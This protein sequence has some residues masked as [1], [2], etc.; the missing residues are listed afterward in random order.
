MSPRNIVRHA[1]KN[2]LD[3]IGICDHN[4]CENVPHVKKCA[5]DEELYIIGGME[6]TSS[7]EVHILALFDEEEQLFSM[8]EFVYDHLTGTNDE[9]FYGEQVVVDENDEIIEY[10]TK[11]LIGA[12]ELTV[13]QIV[14][15]IHQLNGLAIA[16]HVDR[17]SFSIIGQLG[18][19]PV[20]LLI[21]AIEVS[22]NDKASSFT[23]LNLPLITSSDAHTLDAIGRSVTDFYMEEVNIETMRKSFLGEDGRTVGV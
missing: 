12:T 3:I 6:V 1:K 16:S 2:R 5:Q 23:D 7:E 9:K 13:E 22:T 8:Q 11:L 14:A 17:Q 10:N 21:D 20:G 19:I 4:T 15:M 18:F